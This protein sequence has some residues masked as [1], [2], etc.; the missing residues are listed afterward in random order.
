M[1]VKQK[2][3]R[4]GDTVKV[5]VTHVDVEERMI[6]FQKPLPKRHHHNE[7]VDH[8]KSD[9][10]GKGKKEKRKQRKGK[11]ARK[12]DKQGNTHHKPFIKIKV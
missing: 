8:T 7:L 4:I 9:R 1:N 11:N 2:V 6:D 3:F 5:K 12:K 10:N